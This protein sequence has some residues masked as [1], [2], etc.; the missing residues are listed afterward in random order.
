MQ[1][2]ALLHAMSHVPTERTSQSQFDVGPSGAGYCSQCLAYVDAAGAAFGSAPAIV[3]ERF[4][5][6]PVAVAVDSISW[7]RL[8]VYLSR[9]PPLV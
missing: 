6:R 4:D 2:G 8:C 1:Q 3:L 7:R 9:A 5:A